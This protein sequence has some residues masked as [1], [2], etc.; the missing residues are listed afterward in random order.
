[1]ASGDLG[2]MQCSLIN[3]SAESFVLYSGPEL[4]SGSEPSWPGYFVQA[5]PGPGAIPR[6]TTCASPYYTVSN[7]ACRPVPNRELPL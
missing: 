3:R 7:I 4:I 2:H 6:R 5:L 1:M